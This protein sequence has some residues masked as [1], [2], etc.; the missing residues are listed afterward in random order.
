MKTC[1]KHI[2]L[3]TSLVL[4]G[5]EKEQTDCDA[6]IPQEC[7]GVHLPGAAVLRLFS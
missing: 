5:Q 4:Y 7:H 3:K 2:T 1:L 6:I